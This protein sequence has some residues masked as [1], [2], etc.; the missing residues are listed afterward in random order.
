GERTFGLGFNLSHSGLDPNGVPWDEVRTEVHQ[1][2]EVIDIGLGVVKLKENTSISDTYHYDTEDPSK[3]NNFNTIL[4]IRSGQNRDYLQSTR[5]R[6]LFGQWDA[7]N[8]FGLDTEGW[9]E[10]KGRDGTHNHQELTIVY[11]NNEKA[12][13]VSGVGDGWFEQTDKFGNVTEGILKQDYV[14]IANQARLQQSRTITDALNRDGSTN[15]QNMRVRYTLHERTGRI[16][17]IE[18]NGNFRSDDGF[19]NLNVGIL[20]QLYHQDFIRYFQLARVERSIT[21]SDAS[22]RDGSSSHTESVVTNLYDD[23]TTKLEDV[24]GHSNTTG[25]DGFGNRTRSEAI[26]V[27]DKDVLLWSG[28]SRVKHQISRSNTNNQDWSNSFQLVVVSNEYD[29]KTALL[30]GSVGQGILR[31]YDGY[32][33]HT[34]GFMEQEFDDDLI[35]A[36]GQARLTKSQTLTT[37]ADGTNYD[38]FFSL[39]PGFVIFNG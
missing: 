9:A 32:E 25:T 37:T 2:F 7:S 36:L 13:V 3:W 19:G 29:P 18:G 28:Q 35:N 33:G 21:E 23:E 14:G 17:N 16:L 39:P 5:R 4:Q 1:E 20:T 24:E 31:S 30:E 22:N 27:Y 38:A 34:I 8:G 11:T 6:S 12:R 10:E 26:Q 15:H